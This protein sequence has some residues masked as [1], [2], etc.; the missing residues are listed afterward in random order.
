VASCSLTLET[1]S[2][3]SFLNILMNFFISSITDLGVAVKTGGACGG[4]RSFNKAIVDVVSGLV[5][6]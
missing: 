5:A 1:I 4:I 3:V 2:S 6:E